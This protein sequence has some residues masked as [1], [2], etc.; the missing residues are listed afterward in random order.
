MNQEKIKRIKE[1]YHK[2]KQEGLTD[3]EK[4]EQQKL[5]TEYRM[6]IIN[7]LSANLDNVRIK[8]ADGSLSKLEPKRH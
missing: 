3:A 2:S 5:R 6:S 1:L 4:A 8:N 7:S